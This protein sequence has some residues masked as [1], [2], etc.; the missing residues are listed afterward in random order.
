MKIPCPIIKRSDKPITITVKQQLEVAGLSGSSCR[1]R[2]PVLSGCVFLY[3]LKQRLRSSEP[4][5]N[6][7][8]ESDV[9]HFCSRAPLL[10]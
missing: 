3:I 5:A 7:N 6:R 10:E 9:V 8:L 4:L 2:G 1:S